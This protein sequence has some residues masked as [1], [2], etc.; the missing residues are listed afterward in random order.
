MIMTIKIG[1]TVI[2]AIV[3]GYCLWSIIDETRFHRTWWRIL[4]NV[5]YII[6]GTLDILILWFK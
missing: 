1:L 3:M 2:L 4:V 6:I 5:I